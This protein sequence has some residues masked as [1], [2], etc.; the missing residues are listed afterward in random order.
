MEHIGIITNAMIPN[1]NRFRYNKIENCLNRKAI[2]Y[3][4]SF[5]YIYCKKIAFKNMTV[6]KSDQQHHPTTSSI[7]VL[8]ICI[9]IAVDNSKAGATAGW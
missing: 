8:A 5:Y 1:V 7:G 3:H 9:V 2:G 6:S 4:V